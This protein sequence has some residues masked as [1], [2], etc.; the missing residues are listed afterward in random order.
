MAISLR[1]TAVARG[2]SQAADGLWKSLLLKPHDWRSPEHALMKLLRACGKS[3]ATGDRNRAY[4]KR[5]REQFELMRVRQ[6]KR[7]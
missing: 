3:T 4:T 6:R 2:S 5:P 7:R 1:R